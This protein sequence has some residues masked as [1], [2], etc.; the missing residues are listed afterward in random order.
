MRIVAAIGGSIL[1]QDYNAERFKEYAEILKEL[2]EEHEIFVVVGG[3][4]PARDYITAVR[5]LGAG[6]AKCDD[7]G[8]EVTRLN[9]K[10]L[11]LALGN[12]AYQKVP[13]NFGEA[14]EYSAS[15][16]IIVMGGTEPAHSTDAV[17]A[18]LAEYVQADLLINLTSVDGMYTKDPRKYDDAELIEEITATDMI[19]F[20]KGNDVKAGTY[21]FFDMTAIQMI[22]R[23]NLETVIANGNKPQNLVK[24]IKGEK[25]GTRV[26]SE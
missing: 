13:H 8:I 5:N 10:L 24:A 21:E 1:L 6:E 9:A 7:I 15:G 25:I 16:K 19:E 22:K 17:S 12:T 3:G 20:I 2:S 26:I 18:I 14:L 11:L 23:S 4:K